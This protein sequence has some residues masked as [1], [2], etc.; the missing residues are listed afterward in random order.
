MK[1]FVSDLWQMKETRVALILS[2]TL[3]LSVFVYCF[4][5]RYQMV[6]GAKEAYMYNRITGKYWFCAGPFYLKT[7]ER[8]AR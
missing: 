8:S 6:A 5:T 1:K 3:L 4:G 2:I 7:E